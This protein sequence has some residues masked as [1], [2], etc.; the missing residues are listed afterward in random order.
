MHVLE[1]PEL[2]TSHYMRQNCWLTT[3]STIRGIPLQYTWGPRRF[4]CLCMHHRGD[5]RLHEFCQLDRRKPVMCGQLSCAK[6]NESWVGQGTKVWY[7]SFHLWQHFG[8]FGSL[9]FFIHGTDFEKWIMI[10]IIT[11]HLWNLHTYVI[12]LKKFTDSSQHSVQM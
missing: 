6:C 4:T 1:T 10:N 5:T 3:V 12:P 7:M 9:V 2:G 8:W 11:W